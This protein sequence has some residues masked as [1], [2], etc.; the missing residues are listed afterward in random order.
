MWSLGRIIS[1]PEVIRVYISSFWDQ[2]FEQN[3]FESL[4]TS[5]QMELF[6]D[7]SH[8]PANNL[9]RKINDLIR[10]AK[11]S[12]ALALLLSYL[13][14]ESNVWMGKVEKQE[15]LIKEMPEIFEKVKNQ[16]HLPTSDFPS[17]D[18]FTKVISKMAFNKLPRY[19]SRK[20]DALDRES[21]KK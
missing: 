18:H 20:I 14:S 10:R 3:F 7:I 15:Q 17:I 13:Q 4:F 8:L 5:E 2:P 16:N 21:S 1:H 12:K 19:D 11:E 6:T 9:L